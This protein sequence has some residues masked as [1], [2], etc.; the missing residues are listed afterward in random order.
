MAWVSLG[1]TNSI[2]GYD[3]TIYFEVQYEESN[4]NIGNNTSDV[5]LRI[6]TRTDPDY[7]HR[8]S[9]GATLKLNGNSTSI[10]PKG[11]GWSEYDTAYAQSATSSKIT[12]T[13]ENDG[14][15]VISYSVSVNIGGV[16]GAISKSGN[17]T[18]TTIPRSSTVTV[19]PAL[20]D[21]V[22]TPL[23]I[24]VDLKDSSYTHTVK[25]SVD[26][27]DTTPVTLATKVQTGSFSVPYN[28]IKAKVGVYT[29]ATI[30]VEVETFRGNT[31]IGTNTASTQF[32]NR[33]KL[34]LSLYDDLEG[35]VGA[36][37][38]AEADE[39]G[40]NVY[41]DTKF[42]LPGDLFL[43]DTLVDYIVEQGTSGN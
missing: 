2:S 27:G 15:K 12:V 21:S 26:K 41:L 33:S 7:Y 42:K 5:Q 10:S 40:F 1:N 28:D 6:L 8:S 13:H 19:S 18:L 20:I 9:N 16:S 43:S 35:D 31:S 3:V 14:K 30:T 24:A 29:A 17:I 32:L 37:I 34:P 36:T 25:W 4:V 23:D 39:G 11:G 22:A 38:G